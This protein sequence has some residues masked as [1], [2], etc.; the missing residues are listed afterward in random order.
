MQPR[1]INR[2]LC[3]ISLWLLSL[4][5]AA[6]TPVLLPQDSFSYAITPY[7]AV[8]EDPSR[9]LSIDD[10]LQREQQL[11][12]SPSHAMALKFSIS[13][14]NFWLRFSIVNPYA[15]ERQIVFTLSDSD[16]DLLQLYDIST[17]GQWQSL[18]NPTVRGGFIQTYAVLL[19][20]PPH[21]THSFM[22]QMHSRGLFNTQARLLS[23]DQFIL[24][25]QLFF[26]LQGLSCG[27]I[28]ATLAF[29]AYL[30]QV[31]RHPLALAAAAYSV[32]VIL[33][34]AAAMGYLSV[35]WSDIPPLVTDKVGEVMLAV[36]SM[37]GTAATATLNWHGHHARTVRL[38]LLS[39]AAA[40][41]LF[42]LL[43]M[44]MSPAA[45]MPLIALATLFSSLLAALLLL[46]FANANQ[47]ARRSLM[48][49]HLIMG[50]G[51]LLAL[52][53]SHNLL[54]LDA[55]TTWAPLLLP[56]LML[57]SLVLALMTLL[58]QAQQPEQQ[59]GNELRLSPALMSQLSHELRTPINGVI[60]MNELL[61]DTPLSLQQRDCCD[62]IA[63]A[64]RDLLHIANEI[65][66][67]ARLQSGAL[68]LE[69]RPLRLSTLLSQ[70]LSDFQ[71]EAMRKQVELVLDINDDLP[72]CVMA[73]PNRLQTVLRNLLARA[74]AYTEQG[75]MSL[76]VTPYHVQQSQGVRIQVQ[77]SSTII[78]QEEL[79]AAF[80]ILQH[81][82][83]VPPGR[84]EKSWN[85]LL[86]RLLLEQMNAVLEV[87]SMTT[88]GASLTLSLPVGT[89]V[90][91]PADNHHHADLSGR[92]ILIVDDSA[93]LRTV[94]ERQVRRWGM[95]PD[96]TYSGK[97]AL[98][99]LRNQSNLGHPYDF[100]VID[101]DMPM[102]SGLQ[103]AER[104]QQDQDI[105]Q[106]PAQLMLTGL[107]ITAVRDEA[108]AAGIELLLSKPAD[109]ERLREALLELL[110]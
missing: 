38:S 21:S 96:S 24:T 107:N 41:P 42:A 5:A 61:A 12:F 79:R 67:L 54:S 28:L 70:L 25:E 106:K 76:H 14:S 74:L 64:G 99:M 35:I 86:T 77:L 68:E 2:V 90:C 60:G 97:E 20:I 3:L 88:Q 108:L 75:E 80:Q 43:I 11:R 84:Q 93:S 72:D 82:F 27:W 95:K 55:F 98:A 34:Q 104:I 30:W 103:L 45:A 7:L 73:D 29:F 46:L 56:L 94:L 83:P 89:G 51:I 13:D 69:K 44:L 109:T 92:R 63:L 8:Y 18:Q 1:P 100:V 49:G 105:V 52:L 66:D 101:H 50:L 102:M 33:Y 22:L 110:R 53:S 59:S 62:T 19:E 58:S 87:E 23:A 57:A 78:R 91:S 48:S 26:M 31:H 39:L 65:S 47:T 15:D 6:S 40:N 32:V 71:Q 16:F 4:T 81:Q 37:T 85:L 10:M 17:P 9:Q 36:M